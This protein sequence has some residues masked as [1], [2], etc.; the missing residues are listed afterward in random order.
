MKGISPIIATI[1]ILLITVAIVGIAY[2]FFIRTTQTTTVA[3]DTSTQTLVA[4]SMVQLSMDSI[5]SNGI[6]IRNSGT[7]AEPAGDVAVYIN[8][9][10][11]NVTTPQV[12]PGAT[13]QI[14]F[15]STFT[16]ADGGSNN[17]KITDGLNTITDTI[18]VTPISCK[19]VYDSKIATA[20]GVYTILINRTN[21][22]QVYC[23]LDNDG[24][25]WTLAA[26]CKSAD[27]CTAGG[28]CPNISSCW[29]INS[30]GNITD[31]NSAS[32]AKLSDSYIHWLLLNGDNLTRS[33]WRQQYRNN[34][35]N[36]VSAAVFNNL[37]NVTLWRST[38]PTV[39]G[40]TFYWKYAF[41]NNIAADM[42]NISAT[43]YNQS[44]IGPLITNNTGCS[45]PSNGWANSRNDSCGFAT[46]YAACESGPSM[47]HACVWASYNERADLVLWIR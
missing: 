9:R 22:T 44:W 3:V 47:S 33:W 7:A 35:S 1:L 28:Q 16:I 30:V 29:N 34:V 45:S 25:G 19:G 36:P 2:T 43:A 12:D 20:D 11:V 40:K 15:P 27:P 18:T 5:S 8:G 4:N 26:V 38:P 17:L 10:P 31:P 32:A 13:A 6:F 21:Y 14:I 46:W 23:D 39:S 24:G 37:S 41:A 42:I